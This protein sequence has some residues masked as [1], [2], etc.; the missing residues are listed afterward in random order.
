MARLLT[1]PGDRLAL[2]SGFTVLLEGAHEESA[3]AGVT[4]IWVPVTPASTEVWA[5]GA[6]APS[7]IWTSPSPAPAVWIDI[8]AA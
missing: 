5:A 2:E 6:P 3:P 4:G 1:E 7:N 8:D